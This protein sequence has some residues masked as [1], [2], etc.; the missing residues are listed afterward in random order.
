MS[1]CHQLSSLVFSGQLAQRL[2]SSH[3]PSLVVP[4]QR[5][6]SQDGNEVTS[7]RH[8][9]DRVVNVIRSLRYCLDEFQDRA[10]SLSRIWLSRM[11]AIRFEERKQ[12]T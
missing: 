8:L 1:L 11:S 12:V 10:D 4:Q 5:E 3:D 7:T 6:I 9:Q 2:T